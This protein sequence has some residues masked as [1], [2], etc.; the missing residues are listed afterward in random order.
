MID[1]FCY[2]VSPNP[3]DDLQQNNTFCKFFIQNDEIMDFKD[4]INQENLYFIKA[5]E[6][7]KPKNIITYEDFDQYYK[8]FTDIEDINEVENDNYENPSFYVYISQETFFSVY[9]NEKYINVIMNDY[10]MNLAKKK[11]MDESDDYN[12]IQDRSKNLEINLTKSDSSIS[13]NNK[14]DIYSINKSRI[15]KKKK[16]EELYFP[17]NPG[18]GIISS[19]RFL[20]ESNPPTSLN[21]N[22]ILPPNKDQD[23][24]NSGDKFSNSTNPDNSDNLNTDKISG[25]ND[26]DENS[27]YMEQIRNGNDNNFFKFTTKK[28]FVLPNGKKR[29]I[30]KKRKFKS[31]DIRK[32]IKSR[33]HKT[34]KNIINE[35]LKK[36]GSK[37]FFDFLPQCFIGNISKKINAECLEMTYKELLSTNFIL[38]KNNDDYPNKNIDTRKYMKNLEVLKYLEKNPE[39]CRKSGFDIISEKKYKDLLQMYFSSG[40]FEESIVRLKRENE[41][42]DY[43][44]EYILKARSYVSFYSNFLKCGNNNSD[45]E[46]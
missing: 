38:D 19:L 22:F 16:A 24:I 1:E 29:R 9:E 37:K 45:D 36:V 42:K 20:E 10:D 13:E 31:D 28:Y 5:A 32:K 27:Y 39:I 26:D 21:Q 23:S 33:F 6:E 4:E 44:Q 2:S 14:Y 40:E 7:K 43:I 35:N 30:K 25:E 11:M 18:K 46:E 12:Q 17:F 15:T 34:L 8:K 3:Y 41:T